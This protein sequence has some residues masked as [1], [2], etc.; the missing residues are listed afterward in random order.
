MMPEM[1][2][3]TLAKEIRRGSPEM[4]VI[5]LTHKSTG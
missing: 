3:L 5:F 4:P 2:G 1:D